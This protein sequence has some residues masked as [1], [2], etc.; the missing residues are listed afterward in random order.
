MIHFLLYIYPFVIL[1]AV[2]F[3]SNCLMDEIAHHKHNSKLLNWFKR[4]P[5]IYNW[6]TLPWKDRPHYKWYD[7]RQMLVDG[8]HTA[9][10]VMFLS[11]ATGFFII[12]WVLGTI[13]LICW[14]V[15]FTLPYTILKRANG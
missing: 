7:L 2:A 6:L 1:F 3:L 5:K 13:F 15:F 14:A 10:A 9:K 8:W 4:F 11:F 12:N